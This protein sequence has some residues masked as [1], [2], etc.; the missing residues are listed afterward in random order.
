M[1]NFQPRQLYCDALVQAL[2]IMS[3]PETTLAKLTRGF[4]VEVKAAGSAR[5]IIATKKKRLF[6]TDERLMI[7]AFEKEQPSIERLDWFFDEA[8][9]FYEANERS[10]NITGIYLVTPSDVDKATF[11]ALMKGVDEDVSKR[12]KTKSFG[13]VTPEPEPTPT[14][15][16]TGGPPSGK[17][18]ATTLDSLLAPAAPKE[19][20]L[21]TWEM[22]YRESG[23]PPVPVLVTVTQERC[24]AF[25]RVGPIFAHYGMEHRWDHVTQVELAGN[26]G[27]EF[28]KINEETRQ[29]ELAHPEAEFVARTMHHL[30]WTRRGFLTGFGESY[31][32]DEGLV[33]AT[34]ESLLKGKYIE[35]VR[36]GFAHVESSIRDACNLPDGTRTEAV[37]QTAFA[38]KN[39]LFRFGATEGDYIGLLNFATG[40]FT[41]FRNPSAHDRSGSAHDRNQAIQA[42]GIANSL[43]DLL[44]RGKSAQKNRPLVR[45]ATEP[46]PVPSHLDGP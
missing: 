19:R 36:N 12:I 23:K 1:R 10:F 29:V 3:E 32:W 46:G 44:A 45:P 6:E 22:I 34:K 26:P 37:L 9:K 7:I 25:Q 5:R 41:L 40:A 31:D 43:L 38:P 35:A 27:S 21:Y 4:A 2:L 39:G 33:A 13:E 11:K 42:L 28:V 24:L 14:T 18:L 8:V 20:V 17:S 30:W 16:I 15:I